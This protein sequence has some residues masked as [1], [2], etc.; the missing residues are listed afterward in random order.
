MTGTSGAGVVTRAGPADSMAAAEFG[1]SPFFG[2]CAE[3]QRADEVQFITVGPG[4]LTAAP[5]LNAA[6]MVTF[7]GWL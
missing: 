7:P 2:S 5:S 4:Q 1:S 6:A 3:L